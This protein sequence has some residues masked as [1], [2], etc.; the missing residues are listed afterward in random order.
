M[1]ILVKDVISIRIAGARVKTVRSRNI[2]IVAETSFGVFA[3]VIPISI[4]GIVTPAANRAPAP[5]SRT[6][7]AKINLMHVFFMVFS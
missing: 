2:C 7:A 5:T 6:A 4:F 1:I 3:V